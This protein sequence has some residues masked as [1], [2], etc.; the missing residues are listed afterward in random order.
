MFK[1]SSDCT[2]NLYVQVCN[3]MNHPPSATLYCVTNQIHWIDKIFC[4]TKPL[5]LCIQH[6][7]LVGFKEAVG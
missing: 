5:P 7:I 6:I 3:Y 2:L 4:N 1:Y